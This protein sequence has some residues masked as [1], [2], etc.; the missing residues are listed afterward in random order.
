MVEF[1]NRQAET[2]SNMPKFESI[3]FSQSGWRFSPGVR[4]RR[5]INPEDRSKTEGSVL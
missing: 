4:L 3:Y 5:M 2:G 1:A